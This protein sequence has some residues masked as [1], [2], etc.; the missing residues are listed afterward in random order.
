[1]EILLHV[2]CAPCL[3]YPLEQLQ[4]KKITN[5]YY[6]PN[7]H[8]CDEFI[9]RK[10]WVERLSVEGGL[11]VLTYEYNPDSYLDAVVFSDKERCYKC[12]ELRLFETA[13]VADMKDVDAF[14]TTLLS[15]PHQK[16]EMIVDIAKKASKK[17]NIPFFYEDY[18]KGYKEGL[19]KAKEMGI[20]RQKYCGCIYSLKEGKNKFIG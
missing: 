15:S 5:F 12:Y 13:R 17:Y 19:K 6:N 10:E 4:G 16:H 8:P 11:D 3:I 9:K 18:R 2:C 7:I 1:M 20:Y 14:S